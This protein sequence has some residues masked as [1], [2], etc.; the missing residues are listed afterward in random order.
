[1]AMGRSSAERLLL[2][3]RPSV[4]RQQDHQACC[5]LPQLSFPVAQYHRVSQSPSSMDA[6][7]RKIKRLD[8]R[9][10]VDKESVKA[11]LSPQ[12]EALEK[13]GIVNDKL[14]SSASATIGGGRQQQSQKQ[15]SAPP[16]SLHVRVRSVHAAQTFDV[17]KI[18][19]KVFTTTKTPM[20]HYFGKTSVIVQL[21]PSCPGEPFRFVAV[22][23]F[24][25]VVFFNMS[26][27]ESGKLLE[28]IK[29][30]G[31]NPTAAGFE[32]RENFGVVIQ[33]QLEQ[34]DFQD[35]EVV[36]GDYCVVESLDLNS[37]SVVA[38]IMAQTVALDSYND[39][40]E[41]LLST[42]ADIN[43]K[44]RQSGKF[45]EMQKDRYVREALVQ[46]C[47]T[48]VPNSSSSTHAVCFV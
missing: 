9:A 44:V 7:I 3:S 47:C 22:Y 20:R 29:R 43:S 45:T 28:S 23:R 40:A 31:K 11:A 30:Y 37:V 5:C 18:L 19:S 6:T 33:P 14:K 36:T 26:T 10:N 34:M 12:Q 25:S 27:R 24:G 46:S 21:K 41:E 32:R 4:V 35:E 16:P 2:R 48:F 39:I 38:N 1:M 17:V 8:K 42:F 15:V 13:L